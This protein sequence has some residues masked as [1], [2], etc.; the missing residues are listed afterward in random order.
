MG[1]YLKNTKFKSAGYV[2]GVPVGSPSLTTESPVDGLM[3]YNSA[4]N[5]LEYFSL[6]SWINVAHSGSAVSKDTFVGTGLTAQFGPM[7]YAYLSGDEA[8]VLV[9]VNTVFQNPGV[10]YLFNGTPTLTFNTTPPMD[11]VI[12]VLHGYAGA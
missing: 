9:F 12:I 10:D 4:S 5:A 6:G 11:A 3:R 2:L 7:T 1:R 8:R